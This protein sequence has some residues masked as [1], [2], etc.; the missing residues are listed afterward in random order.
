MVTS[1]DAVYEIHEDSTV[2]VAEDIYVDFGTLEK[3]GIFR[4]L[5]YRY[6][7][8]G[9]HDR[10]ITISDVKVEGDAGPRPFELIQ[11]DTHL[12][13]KIGDPD[14]LVSGVQR[15]RITYLLTG[16]LNPFASTDEFFWNV[17][18]ADW[19][20][21]IERATALVTLPETGIMRT[22]CYEGPTGST[23]PCAMRGTDSQASFEATAT[24]GLGSEM[25]LLVELTKGVV[26]VGQ[27]TLANRLHAKGF[28][29]Y[30]KFNGQT[31]S[32][33]LVFGGLLFAGIV[34]LWWAAGR[35][36][37]FG[38][39]AH[40]D[41]RRREATKPLFAR[42]TIVV[43]YQPPEVASSEARRMRPAE[44]GVLVD[45]RAD[46][47]DVSATIVDLAVRKYLLIKETK[48]G[49]IFGLFQTKDYE[50]TRLDSGESPL[51]PYEQT[52]LAALFEGGTTVKMSD[53]KN[54][55]HDDLAKV[56][57]ELYH[58]ITT[59][60]RFFPRNP[61]FVRTVYRI[62]G[63]VMAG[64]GVALTWLLAS[65]VGWGVVGVP[66][67]IAG[68]VLFLLAH[69]MPRRTALGRQMYRRAMGFKLYMLTAEKERQ[70]FAEERNI[71][72]DYLP[73][74]IVFECVDKWAEAFEGLA[75]EGAQPYWY[76]G[77]GPF[78]PVRFAG[79]VGEFSSS[80]S[81]VMASTPGGRGGSGF[82]GGGG[83]G[84][85]GGGGGGG[86]W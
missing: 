14:V 85:G 7:Y 74:A 49:G 36:R 42:E 54:K 43:E 9:E 46:T 67:V 81:N 64:A 65:T 82:G 52:L 17:T 27:P 51:L 18:G 80:V 77:T 15:Y 50:L 31:I 40:L 2:R 78:V 41:E 73:Y 45:E 79:S 24:L 75:A 70:R 26:D 8:D 35:D 57:E 33:S 28:S 4:D 84:G 16:A 60:D 29:D 53:L 69:L 37:W 86:S 61:E 19:P 66:L 34:R 48:E 83:A 32:L 20:V 22:A 1:F 76:S 39:M 30:F 55:F 56:K 12:Q 23:D 13:V 63:A 11:S 3:H 71:F 38:D 62:A 44:I 5:P 68:A 72:H 10:L 25:T 59:S 47:L 58:Q 6:E 21:P